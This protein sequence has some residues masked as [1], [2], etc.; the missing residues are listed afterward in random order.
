MIT[1]NSML[2]AGNIC[3]TS[4]EDGFVFIQNNCTGVRDAHTESTLAPGSSGDG[5]ESV[6]GGGAGEFGVG[7]IV[8]GG[9]GWRF[10]QR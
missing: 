1:P 6:E 8:R 2:D 3:T 5:A 9:G 10:I 7:V 4:A